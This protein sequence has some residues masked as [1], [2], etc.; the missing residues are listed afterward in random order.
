MSA[1]GCC[2]ETWMDCWEAMRLSWHLEKLPT[3]MLAGNVCQLPI[4]NYQFET[5]E[6][7]E[8]LALTPN[9]DDLL[10]PPRNLRSVH[11]ADIDCELSTLASTH[12]DALVFF[13]PPCLRP[14]HPTDRTSE[15]RRGPSQLP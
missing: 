14:L 6:Y 3:D 11:D 2:S 15:R 13:S 12:N 8:G 9:I 4:E 1:L 7:R 5:A 10:E